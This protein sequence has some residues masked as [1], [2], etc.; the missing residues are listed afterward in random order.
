M[1]RLEYWRDTLC[2]AMVVV[3]GMIAGC[4]GSSS[5]S[6]A[7]AADTASSAGS[8]ALNPGTSTSTSTST[9]SG[10]TISGTPAASV[11]AGQAYAFRPAATA[12]SGATVQ[13]SIAGRPAWATFNLNTGALTGTPTS[14]DVGVNVGVQITASDGTTSVATAPFEITV[15]PPAAASSSPASTLTPPA[16]ANSTAGNVTL[17]WAA[18]TENTNGTNLTNLGGY[19]IYYGTVSKQY[20]TTIS[21]SSPATLS[22]VIDALTVGQTYYFAV[23]AVSA[24][25]IESSYSPEI[26]A[27]IS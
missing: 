20:S 12:P 23:T 8:T 21:V 25:G 1:V 17:G 27:T 16:T 13:Y 4:G 18:P 26:S 9:S 2:C 6:S 15:N 10:L 14:A 7:T 5:G 11:V 19:K 24:A 3:S 22:Y